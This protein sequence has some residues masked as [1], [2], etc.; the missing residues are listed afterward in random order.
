MA[1]ILIMAGGTGGHIMPALSLAHLLQK[2]GHCIHWV[3][4]QQGLEAELVPKANL[5][6]HFIRVKG[7]RNKGLKAKLKLPFELFSA[8]LQA[9]QLINNLKPDAVV[10]FGG[11]V[12]GPGG[13]AAKLASLPLIIH[14]QNAKSGMT[15]RWLAKVATLSFQAFPN[16]IKGARTVGNPVRA[17]FFSV[18]REKNVNSPLNVLVVGGSLG[19]VALNDAV[20]QALVSMP[21]SERPQVRHQVGKK[22]YAQMQNAYQQA[23]VEVQLEAFIEDMP[24]AFAQADLLIC[25]AGALTVSEVA[26][27]SKAALFVPYPYAVDDHQTLNARYL[28]EQDAA[29]LCPQ[30]DL[31]ATWLAQ[32][33][34]YF[35]KHKEVLFAMG[36]KARSLAQE[37]ACVQIS[38]G[39]EQQLSKRN[40]S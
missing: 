20:L 32:Q 34:A 1:T 29:M 40:K 3:G 24:Q 5:P 22:N 12:S 13:L 4:T 14:E 36:R 25:R 21:E 17:D 31:T 33:F 18:H 28:S 30:K 2:Q 35:S 16:A 15:N 7:V 10:G 9:R 38:Q 23:K 27:A 39:L 26:A 6:L 8:L 19:A 37:D 11:Y